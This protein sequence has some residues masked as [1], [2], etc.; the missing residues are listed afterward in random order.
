MA[1]H[2][3][4]RYLGSLPESERRELARVNRAGLAA[5]R[6]HLASG[7]AVAFLGA[8]ASAPLYPTWTALIRDLVNTATDRLTEL[9]AATLLEEAAAS[10]DEV[11]EIVR[12]ILGVPAYREVLREVLRVRTDPVSGRTW[13]PVQELVCRCSFKAIITTNYDPGI[14][15]ARIRI[16][17]GVSATGFTTWEDELGLDRWRTGDVFGDIELPVLYAHGQ[18]NRPD[19]V[20]LATTEY[21]RAYVGKLAQVL[22]RL[23]DAA[24][25]VWIGFS[26]ADQRI[27]AI[28]REIAQ[29]SGTRID[30]GTAPR[31]VVVTSWD[32]AG[33]SNDPGILAQRMEIACGAQLVLYP[34]RGGD[35]SA[36]ELLLST[37]TDPRFAAAGEP[38]RDAIT[39]VGASSIETAERS[40]GELPMRWEPVPK[41]VE[42]FTGR[43]EELARLNRWAE[44]PQVKLVGVTAWGGA[45]KTAL[46]TNWVLDADGV[47][48]R[49]NVEGVFGWSFYDDPSAEH[50]AA[51]LLGWTQRQFKIFIQPARLAS[52]V[53]NVLRAVP[54]LLVLDGLEVL[55]ESPSGDG[56]GRVLD[57]T[58]REVLTSACRLQLPGLIILTSRFPFA[59]LESFDGDSARILEVPA[60]TSRE[61]SALL[62]TAGG[63]WL[64]DPERRNLV[65]AVDGHALAVG[66]LAGVL[67]DRP[68]DND[69]VVLRSELI[70]ATRTSA[71]VSRV[72]RFY[73][74]RLSESDRYLVA[75]VSLF[76]RPVSANSVL[77]V[78]KHP[79]FGDRLTNW[80]PSQVIEAARDRLGGLVSVQ[81]N[82]TLSAHPL[83]RD[84]FRPLALG[85]ANVA[86][87]AVL[88]GMPQGVIR[89]RADGQLVVEAIEL[90]LDAGQW[91]GAD[92]LY[93]ARTADGRIWKHLPSA[94]LGQRAGSAFVAT[95]VRRSA[96][97][98]RLSLNDQACYLNISGLY[99]MYS[100]D[101]IAAVE[102][103]TEAVSSY[104]AEDAT[105]NLTI[106]LYNLAI[107]HGLS[108]NIHLG[109]KAALESLAY[110]GSDPQ[111][112]PYIQACLGWL[113][114]L[115]GDSATAEARFIDADEA[116]LYRNGQHLHLLRGIQW[117]DWLLTTGRLGAAKALT[118]RNR[119]TSETNAWNAELAR[120]DRVLACVALS[121][122]DTATAGRLLSAA[123]VCFREGD[124][125]TDLALTLF[126]LA[127]HAR[128]IGDLGGAYQYANEALSIAGPRGLV[129]TQVS[130]L[131]ARARIAASHVG[132]SSGAGY[133][134]Q[135]RDA[136][137]A[138]LRLATR[139]H[140]VFHERAALSA[141]AELDHV[142]GTDHGWAD[143]ANALQ[144]RLVPG[145]LDADPLATLE[146]LN[147]GI[148]QRG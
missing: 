131:V 95:A 5:L 65:A 87:D 42:H 101:V 14:V 109:Q 111:R 60:L 55:Q 16:R 24:H 59:D 96:C 62:A 7:Q 58:L 17:P 2:P 78:T 120:C 91:Q 22:A 43:A 141:H 116:Q 3:E 124:Y 130:A 144:A 86:A 125:L 145:D 19:S 128:L 75:A 127:E 63:E 11:V 39:L 104:R 148:R 126:H 82:E 122:G 49:T 8:G 113:A 12:R 50:W 133:V 51:A 114:G 93:G 121:L 103:F 79:V 37:L 85:A 21:R 25:L 44:D 80:T 4:E 132:A 105:R 115:R 18:S 20:I 15:D 45:G 40:I 119:E 97:I 67:A 139:H 33:Q 23:V 13:T 28:L 68:A 83:V 123:A 9:Q 57:G 26:F 146:T 47:S 52:R 147:P 99:A 69:L 27:A 72:L 136:A 32:P 107:C 71:R 36:L 88:S 92:G 70:A 89:T 34:A 30:P 81:L 74:E 134:V 106:A 64:A 135:G 118:Q 137:D 138:A 112:R 77:A 90:L 38:P 1:E 143:R 100:G 94:R 61:G 48:H 98:A 54:L 108:G 117:A 29:T 66:V 73:A 35:H 84:S 46:V 140:L 76:A 10:P 142:E 102:Y 129:P 6:E 41:S 110:G 53:L 31:H 56:F